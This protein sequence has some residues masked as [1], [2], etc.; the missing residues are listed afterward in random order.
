M[1]NQSNQPKQTNTDGSV[2]ES[3]AVA[4]PKPQAV[5]PIQAGHGP[6]TK[7]EPNVAAHTSGDKGMNADKKTS[8]NP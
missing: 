1:N 3:P 4:T 2:K 8:M 5:P 7:A 6:Q